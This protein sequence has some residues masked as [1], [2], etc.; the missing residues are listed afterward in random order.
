VLDDFRLTPGRY[1]GDL[2][3]PHALTDYYKYYFF[4]RRADMSYPVSQQDLGYDG[5]LLDLLSVNSAAV[6]EHGRRHGASLPH[7]R[8]AFATA[9]RLFKAIDVPTE[10]VITPYDE[11]AVRLIKRLKRADDHTDFWKLMRDA[12]Q[13]SVSVFPQ[14]LADLRRAGAVAPASETNGIL[15]LDAGFYSGQFGLSSTPVSPQELLYV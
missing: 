6:A 12:Q 7:W 2:L 3:G 15:L 14:T 8:Q 13:Y 4:D 11:V 9:A 1:G 10:A 5:N